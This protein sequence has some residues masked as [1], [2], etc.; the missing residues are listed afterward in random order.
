MASEI[1]LLTT[2]TALIAAQQLVL[3]KAVDQLTAKLGE[4][5]NHMEHRVTLLEA[6][7]ADVRKLLWLG[8]GAMLTAGSAG[9]VTILVTVLA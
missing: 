6:R 5:T 2:Q 9:V 7:Q 1:E 8:I 3:V 4:L